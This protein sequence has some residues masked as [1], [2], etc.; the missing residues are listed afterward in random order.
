[1]PKTPPLGKIEYSVD[2]VDLS[3]SFRR[4]TLGRS[5]Y[6]TIKSSF[7]SRFFA[8]KRSVPTYTDVLKNLRLRI[9]KGSSV[10]VIGRNGS[11]KSTLLK[12][13][14]GI[15]KP[16]KGTVDV[17]GKI[18]A[19]IELGAGFH[20]D[21]TGRENL[22]LGAAMHGMSKKEF[23][24]AFDQ[25][26]SFAEL[27]HVIDDPVKTYS[28]GM[29]M[30]LGFSLAIHTNPDILIVDE[31]LAVGDAA[32]VAKC[33]EK[34][35][36]LRKDKKTLILVTHDLDAVERWCDEV[37][38]L[39]AGEVKDRGDP[40]RVIDHYRQ[41]IEQGEEGE[42]LE[43][44]DHRKG[45]NI[46]ESNL[47]EEQT[48]PESDAQ[49]G[50]WGSREVEITEIRLSKEDGSRHLLFHPEDE[51]H[52]SF[53]YLCRQDISDVVF[54]ICINRSD[55][56][57]VHGS[58]TDIEKVQLSVGQK[59]TIGYKIKYLGLLDGNYYLDVAVH[60]SDGYPYDYHKN[61]LKFAVRSKFNQVGVYVP[62]HTWESV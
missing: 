38:W 12:L 33:K 51:L 25:I 6:T 22:A 41:F 9:P 47:A 56:L 59:G 11:G 34:I 39:H 60:R 32:F 58:N 31:V 48:A 28:S 18:A 16:D 35:A 42:L 37:L 2:I 7:L 40:R 17:N 29:F 44:H 15:Y 45:A 27:G 52:L 49:P 20:P 54:G 26:V 30:R 43:A 21:F 13:I 8:I 5:N 61:S 10:G 24:Q 3:K 50:R 4:R 57:I 53:D 23:N 55:G 19:L 46:P 14:T 62:Q 1:M 36:K